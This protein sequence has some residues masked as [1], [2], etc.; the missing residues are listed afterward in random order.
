MHHHDTD[1]ELKATVQQLEGKIS[2]M[3]LDLEEAGKELDHEHS[4]IKQCN[5]LFK[6]KL[7]RLI[8]ADISTSTRGMPKE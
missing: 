4:F 6:P 3:S 5:E 2:G 1:K 8:A 7:R